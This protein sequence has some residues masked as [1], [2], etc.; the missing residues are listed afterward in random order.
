[1]GKILS[2]IDSNLDNYASDISIWKQYITIYRVFDLTWGFK[3]SQYCCFYQNSKDT[4]LYCS[5]LP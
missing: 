3:Y 5:T 2:I 4:S 1:M